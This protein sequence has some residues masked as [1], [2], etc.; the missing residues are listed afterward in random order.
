LIER[1]RTTFGQVDRHACD[2]RVLENAL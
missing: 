2:I 1:A